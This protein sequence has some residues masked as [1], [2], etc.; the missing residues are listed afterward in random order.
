MD[1]AMRRY[2]KSFWLP[3]EAQKIER[4]M[5]K[6]SRDYCT[7]NKNYFSDQ[8]DQA[9]VLSVSLILLNKVAHT[10]KIPVSV[11]MSRDQFIK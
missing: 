3:G 11:K 4:I 7:Q 9:Y 8:A 2:F 5:D 6:F 1:K 10:S